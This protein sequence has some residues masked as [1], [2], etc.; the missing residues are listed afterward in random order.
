[1]IAP[2]AAG[3]AAHVTPLPER[4]QA[5]RINRRCSDLCSSA[6]KGPTPAAPCEAK[7]EERVRPGRPTS[8]RAPLPTYCAGRPMS[9]PLRAA[10]TRLFVSTPAFVRNMTP[11]LTVRTSPGTR[12]R[13]SLGAKNYE[14]VIAPAL[15]N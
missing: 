12:A 13:G 14:C 5:S 1:M 8:S 3:A 10:T 4:A 15:S 6:G 2:G 9:P 11:E 7:D